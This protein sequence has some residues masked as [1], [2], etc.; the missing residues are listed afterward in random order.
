MLAEAVL[1]KEHRGVADPDQAWALGE[2]I[3]Y[4]EH[5]R[6]GA[7]EFEDKGSA[8]VAVRNAVADGTLR[9]T[10]KAAT[11]VAGRF[12]AP[13]RFTAL[14]LGTRLG[15]EALV[16]F[17]RKELADPAWR[18]Q[19]HVDN[20][21]Q[22]GRLQGAICIP[23]TAGPLAVVV[24]LRAKQITCSVNIETPRDGRAATKV[25][26]LTRQLKEGVRFAG[27]GSGRPR[28][29][30]PRS[31]EDDPVFRCREQ[32]SD[33]PQRWPRSGII[34]RQL[35]RLGGLFLFGHS[36]ESEGLVSETS[37]HAGAN[38]LGRSGQRS[39]VHETQTH[40]KSTARH[41]NDGEREPQPLMRQFRR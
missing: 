26:W 7:L 33:G 13:L 12:D 27:S 39:G 1:A 36:A 5:P 14:Q 16:V 9:P 11:E 8:W 3:R 22:H 40:V 20:M 19:T 2:L 15:T 24:D 30:D 38:G 37:P 34:H 29:S 28:S 21:V 35:P 25:K 41:E 31:H 23:D 4:L 17:S 18:L 6:S 32:P 10:D